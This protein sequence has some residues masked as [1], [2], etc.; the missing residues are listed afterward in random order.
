MCVTDEAAYNERGFK[1]A[2]CVTPRDV[3]QHV[4]DRKKLTDIVLEG[5]S[6]GG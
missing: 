3:I 1:H 4:S 2:L 6:L 5:T